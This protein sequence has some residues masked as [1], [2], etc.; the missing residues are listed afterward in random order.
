MSPL[1]QPRTVCCAGVNLGTLLMRSITHGMKTGFICASGFNLVAS[2]TRNGRR[3]I[4]VV[5]GAY[6][7]AERAEHAAQLLES[8]FNASPL[9]WLMPSLGSVDSLTPIN[10]EPL[11][12]RD[13]MC[14]KNRRRHGPESDDDQASGSI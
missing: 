10:A 13:E 4:A 8:G 5:L 7:G 1:S 3:L 2:A 12:L 14:G 11:D 9:S 6:S